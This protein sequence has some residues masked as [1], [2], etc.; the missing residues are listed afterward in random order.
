MRFFTSIAHK[1][2]WWLS[3]FYEETGGPNAIRVG[4]S[5]M[6]FGGKL[7]AG[8]LAV[9]RWQIT[10]EAASIEV[11]PGSIIL[12]IVATDEGPFIDQKFLESLGPMDKAELVRP[13]DIVTAG[14][15]VLE[16]LAKNHPLLQKQL[17]ERKRLI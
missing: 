1:Q 11:F 7:P 6:W 10:E 17:G 3:V 9:E 5:K 14:E 2:K 16:E 15:D 13:T 4:S 8:S 12:A